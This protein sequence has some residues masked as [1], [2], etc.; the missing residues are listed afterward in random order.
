MLGEK[1]ANEAEVA[2]FGKVCRL[3]E[4]ITVGGCPIVLASL[5]AQSNSRNR[6]GM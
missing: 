2:L 1:I 6:S 4:V 3:A 5:T